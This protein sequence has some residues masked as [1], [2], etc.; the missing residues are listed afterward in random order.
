MK[1]IVVVL[2][3]SVVAAAL[4]LS[5]A[6]GYSYVRVIVICFRASH[7]THTHTRRPMAKQRE[8]RDVNN[9]PKIDALACFRLSPAC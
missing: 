8:L 7:D 3:P 4:M 1:Y 9:A 2:L 5:T 6:P